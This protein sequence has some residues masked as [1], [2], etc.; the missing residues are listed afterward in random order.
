MLRSDP[1]VAT[2][3]LAAL[4]A[5][6]KQRAYQFTTVTPLTQ[7]RVNAR[8]GAAWAHD[9]PGIFGWSRPFKAAV[10]GPA[11]LELM[12]D[13]GIIEGGADTL[14]AS[15]RASTLDGQL[16]FHSAFPTNR[17]DAVFFGPDTCRF[18]RA[19]RGALRT[20][21]AP[22]RRAVDIGCGAGPGAITMALAYPGA[23]VLAADINPA[24]LALT[25]V[26]A[27]IAG[28][29]NVQA[30]H[31]NLLSDLDGDFDLIISNPP[32][33]VDREQR[34]Y[35]H[36]GGELGAALSIALVR[37]AVDRLAPG[38]ALMLYT[39]VAMVASADPLRVA[40]EPILRA[41]GLRWTYEE[42]DPDVFG[43]ELEHD[44]YAATDRIAAVWLCATRP[45]S[46]P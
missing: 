42:I 31:S 46:A 25:E 13:A 6:L 45:G 28:A 26:N 4:G 1:D 19:L 36:G 33:L 34:A 37:Q 43:E 5:A 35:R 27:A 14:R 20:H 7:H 3:A 30:L 17:A 15:V 22:V 24:A 12:H 39:G 23:T 32:Y 29:A 10:P 44:A 41:A 11:L 9:L 40:V 18:I 38:G 8:A 16:Y 21:G 2:N